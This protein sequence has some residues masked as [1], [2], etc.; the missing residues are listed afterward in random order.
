MLAANTNATNYRRNLIWIVVMT[1]FAEAMAV[2]YLSSE[3]QSS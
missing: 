3:S 1:D 2:V